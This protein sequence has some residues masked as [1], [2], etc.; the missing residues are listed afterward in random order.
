MHTL[1]RHPRIGAVSAHLCRTTW[2][3]LEESRP[4]VQATIVARFIAGA[5][6]GYTS[7]GTLRRA[8]VAVLA[9][10][11]AG[12]AVYLANGL[13]DLSEDRANGSARPIASGRLSP[14]DG[15]NLAG[16][17]AV[18]SLMA[19][20]PADILIQV[21]MFLALGYTYSG[22]PW[23]MKRN[24]AAAPLSIMASGAL[25]FWAAARSTGSATPA[26]IIAGATLSAWMGLVGALVK[27]LPDIP[28]DRT[29]GRKTFAIVFG[30]AW[31]VRGAAASAVAIGAFGFAA[32]AALAPFLIP[33][34]L[35]LL[36][37]GV[38]IAALATRFAATLRDPQAP[39]RIFMITQCIAI[40]LIITSKVWYA[41]RAIT[42]LRRAR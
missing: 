3:G 27:D 14:R 33:A 8:I 32:S 6:L 2:L 37:G 11:A 16:F 10:F 17:L 35:A 39:Y 7:E 30:P 5:V 24:W 34:M 38:L 18:L 9:W 40:S 23:P 42:W 22:P 26:V 13:A 41:H 25:T 19:A 15:L 31:T 1:G 28:G 12:V 29:A 21:A 20:I 4:L 36:V